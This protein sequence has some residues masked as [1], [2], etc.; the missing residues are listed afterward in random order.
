MSSNDES[1]LYLCRKDVEQLCSTI[2]TVAI[3]REVFRLHSLQQTVL[4][5]EAYLGWENPLG[6]TVRSLNMPAYVGGELTAAGTKII[7]GNIA[8]PQRGLP[9]A[10]GLTLL[11]DP[12]TVRIN[13][14]LEGA[15][16]SSL[17]TA[18]VTAL[19][20]D[21]LQGRPIKKVAI[22]GAG[23]LAQAHIELLVKRLPTL[24]KIALFD[25]D[26]QR[27][28]HFAQG[29]AG[30]LH[31]HQV[32]FEQSASAQMAIAE[33]ELVI[34]VTT[35]TTGY[36]P[37]QWLSPG[38]IV[39]NVS[40]DDIL[41]D[42]VLQADAVIVDDWHLVKSD[43]R[44]LLGRMYRAGQLIGPDDSEQEQRPF[45]RKIDAQL[46]DLITGKRIGRRTPEEILLVN[47]FG[48]AIE[49]IALAA[50]IYQEAVRQGKG[51]QLCR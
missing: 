30:L 44:R 20:V 24:Q 45:S 14:I 32:T 26:A 3:I 38:T 15:Y 37:Y 7:N 43:H 18:S 42:V 6:E 47:P 1:L 31:E 33:A 9:R 11:F 46:G 48:L 36:I 51:L 23:V 50:R 49:D 21:L 4:P 16:L 40:L 12:I 13:A 2:D 34:P 29:I 5:D 41:P 22:I 17:R 19:A 39:V 35:T 10:N 28:Q 25:L 8:N 27:S